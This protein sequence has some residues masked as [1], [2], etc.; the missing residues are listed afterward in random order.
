MS[1]RKDVT[2]CNAAMTAAKVSPEDA[3]DCTAMMQYLAAKT[4][5]DAYHVVTGS[6]LCD[7]FYVG[8]P[9]RRFGDR[10]RNRTRKRRAK[11]IRLELKT[12][13]QAVGLLPLGPVIWLFLTSPTLWAFL[14]EW[15]MGVLTDA[16]GE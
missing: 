13:L 11:Q 9:N 1:H 4:G 3:D 5:A 2:L 8:N 12:E 14:L 10:E 15:V 16:E 6:Q 7:V